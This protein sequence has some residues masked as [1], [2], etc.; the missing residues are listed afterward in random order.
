MKIWRKNNEMVVG[1]GA[2]SSNVK[3]STTKK[4]IYAHIKSG[5]IQKGKQRVISVL[6]KKI[7][8]Q[9]QSQRILAQWKSLENIKRNSSFRKTHI[10][11]DKIKKKRS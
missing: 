4:S 1:P 9:A 2:L 8:T 10:D 11:G 6:K 5:R 7:E 3:I